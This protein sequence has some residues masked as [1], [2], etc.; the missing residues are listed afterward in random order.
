MEWCSYRD[1]EGKRCW[2]RHKARGLCHRHY[3]RWRMHGDPGVCLRRGRKAQKL[4]EE[5]VRDIRGRWKYGWG[6]NMTAMAKEYGVSRST[7]SEI[8]YRKIWKHVD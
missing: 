3:D 7:V 6:D 4:D 1:G 2:R 5:K 8:L